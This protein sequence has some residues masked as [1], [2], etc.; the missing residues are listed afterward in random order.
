MWGTEAS[1]RAASGDNE[2]RWMGPQ[3]EGVQTHVKE[4]ELN[5]LE[6]GNGHSLIDCKLAMMEI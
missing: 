3:S 1:E 4:S 6:R 5:P 2:E